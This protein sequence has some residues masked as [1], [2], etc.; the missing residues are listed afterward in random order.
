MT[1]RHYNSKGVDIFGG[2]GG[3][4][5][6]I[7][8][9]PFHKSA[10]ESVIQDDSVAIQNYRKGQIIICIGGGWGGGGGLSTDIETVGHTY[11][12]IYLG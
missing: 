2:L 3:L 1:V 11:I 12:Y 8:F 7:T 5:L 6:M 9:S 4:K 10:R